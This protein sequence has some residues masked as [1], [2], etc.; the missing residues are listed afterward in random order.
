M[1]ELSSHIARLVEKQ[2]GFRR[3]VAEGHMVLPDDPREAVQYDAHAYERLF[4]QKSLEEDLGLDLNK[5]SIWAVVAIERN[6][7][8]RKQIT[9]LRPFFSSD[10]RTHRD[11]ESRLRKYDSN[12][13]NLQ[14]DEAHLHYERLPEGIK[15][16]RLTICNSIFYMGT[17]PSAQLPIQSLIRSILEN[18][19]PDILADHVVIDYILNARGD[20]ERMSPPRYLYEPKTRALRNIPISHPGAQPTVA[21]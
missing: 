1:T 16:T 8:E 12:L 17:E 21:I 3:R 19:S 14:Y 5:G 18:I 13:D 11:F 6:P 4:D 7:R 2:V 15:F 20:A 10:V 9:R